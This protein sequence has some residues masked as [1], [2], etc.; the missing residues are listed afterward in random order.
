MKISDQRN[1]FKKIAGGTKSAFRSTSFKKTP[2]IKRSGEKADKLRVPI[3][4]QGIIHKTQNETNGES[5]ALQSRGFR[6]SVKK[7]P[8]MSVKSS[9]VQTQ[10]PVIINEQEITSSESDD[11]EAPSYA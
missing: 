11:M 6:I 3:G 4:G 2:S 5:E 8:L 9:I 10:T 7:A 1:S